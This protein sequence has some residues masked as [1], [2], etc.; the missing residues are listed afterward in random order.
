M[1][2]I[3]NGYD[4]WAAVYDHDANPLIALEGPIV[5]S[6]LGDP[7]TGMSVL[8]LG[9]GTGRHTS[10]LATA[11]ASVT[12][13]DFSEGML[14]KA[15][16]KPGAATIHFVTH[17]LHQHLPF[18]D[19]AFDL[20]L[21]CLLIEHL[22][23]LDHFFSESIRVLKPGG[24][25]VVTNMHPAMSLRGAQARFTDPDSGELVQ[26]GSIVHSLGSI[27]MSA[28]RA[29][30]T[31]RDIGEYTPDQNLA[32]AFPRAAR[33]V[34]WPMLVLFDLIRPTQK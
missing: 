26:P 6:T 14:E 25:M 3:Q 34:G 32:T 13:V 12:A 4:R 19:A 23:D 15:K 18:N 2:P 21:S 11:A 28:L 5:R 22:V 33:Y 29:G 16:Q 10:W 7:L 20:A 30:F 8:E 9:C 24:R 17:D 31:L 1:N 27:T